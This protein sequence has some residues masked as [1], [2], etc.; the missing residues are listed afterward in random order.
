MIVVAAALL[1]VCLYLSPLVVA[2]P[3]LARRWPDRGAARA[4]DVPLVLAVDAYATLTVARAVAL[5]AAV[6]IARAAWASLGVA[7]L[8]RARPTRASVTAAWRSLDRDA[9]LQYATLALAA[10]ALT[11][12]LSYG[13]V[14]WDREFHVPLVSALRAQTM[15]FQWVLAP[16]GPLRYHY[17]GDAIAAMIQ[18]LSGDVIS[19]GLA[20][21]LAHDVFLSLAPITLFATLRAAGARAGAGWL[22]ALSLCVLLAG[23]LSFLRDDALH[24]FTTTG[25]L[26]LC[27]NSYLCFLTLSYR[28]ANAPGAYFMVALVSLLAARLAPSSKPSQSDEATAAQLIACVASLSMLDEASLGLI[29]LSLGVAWV[30]HPRCLASTRARGLALLLTLAVTIAVTCAAFYSPLVARGGGGPVHRVAIVPARLLGIYGQRTYTFAEAAGR[31]EALFDAFPCL[32]VAVMTLWFALRLRSRAI[33]GL[34]AFTCAL[35]ALGLFGLFK[36]NVNDDPSEAQRFMMAPV[37]LAPAIGAVTLVLAAGR[38]TLSR[39]LM[40]AAIGLPVLSTLLWY[41]SFV[42]ET[43]ANQHSFGD[44]HALDCRVAAG[45]VRRGRPSLRYASHA[46]IWRFAPCQPSF[47]PGRRDTGWDGSLL[48]AFGAA[49]IDSIRRSDP[50]IPFTSVVCAA[51]DDPDSVCDWA[52]THARCVPAGAGLREC[53]LDASQ[54]AALLQE[55]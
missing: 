17:L 37:L 16:V 24:P 39:A 44:M 47:L 1:A 18:T 3:L 8:V 27:G 12:T 14:I 11:S 2:L 50:R 23:P 22:G 4:L 40:L 41:K 7:A 54:R 43:A 42:I 45:R 35:T 48:S 49:A 10:V 31:R 52:T 32:S 20:L 6:W 29:G 5:W 28:P 46:A 36:V 34:A 26:S 9:A 19:S 30:A 53:L 51:G 33:A 15:P 38:A 13:Y 55:F 25:S 21:S